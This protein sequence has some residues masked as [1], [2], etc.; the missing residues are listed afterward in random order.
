MP[1]YHA[2]VRPGLLDLADGVGHAMVGDE[3]EADGTVCLE[4]GEQ[5]GE[6]VV[7]RPNAGGRFGGVR[8]VFVARVVAA[9]PVAHDQPGAVR[10]GQPFLQSTCKSRYLPHQAVRL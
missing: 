9:A 5:P 7:R 3:H 8:A 1:F 6:A 4:G 2:H 10:S